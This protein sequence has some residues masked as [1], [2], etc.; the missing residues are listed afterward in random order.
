MATRYRRMD[1]RAAVDSV[2]SRDRDGSDGP[3]RSEALAFR[4]PWIDDREIGTVNAVLAVGVLGMGPR[5]AEFEAR[6]ASIVGARHAVAVN[7]CW[8]GFHLAVEALALAPGDEILTSVAAATP[9]LAAITHVG[10]RPVLVDVAPATLTLNPE[11]ARQKITGRTRAILPAHFAGCPAAMDEILALA[12]EH[13][14]PVVEDALHALP[15]AYGDRTVGSIG[16]VT[17][18]GL[19]QDLSITTGEGGI[20]TTDRADLAHL[21][22]TRRYY[23]LPAPTRQ[24]SSWRGRHEEAET[25]GFGYQMADLNAAVGLGQLHKITML[26]AIRTYYAGLYELGLSDLPALVL[27]SVPRNA[28]HAWTL[29][30]VRL[31]RDR[32]TIARDAFIEHLEHENVPARVDFVPLYAHRYYR[33]RLALHQ[34]DFPVAREAYEHSISLP[35]YPRMSEADVWD[36]IRAVR[37]VATSHATG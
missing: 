33:E 6:F 16:E 31:R 15:A 13:Q 9:A 20:V 11:Q 4:R 35:L 27:P 32:L 3:I 2:P 29:Y 37:K 17:I 25:Y 23:G 10:A 34:D 8:A 30:V 24:P 21:F 12:A 1:E 19:G 22:R 28:Q 14:L 7:S 18:F 36:V 5:T 26:H